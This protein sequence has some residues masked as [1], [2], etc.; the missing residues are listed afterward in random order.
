VPFALSAAGLPIGIQLIARPHAE[1]TLFAAALPLQ[2]SWRSL[3]AWP[4]FAA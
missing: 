3:A 4:P 2:Q 1:A